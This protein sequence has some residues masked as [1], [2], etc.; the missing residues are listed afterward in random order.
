MTIDN[1]KDDR[2]AVRLTTRLH[3]PAGVQ[4]T[5]YRIVAERGNGQ[6]ALVQLCCTEAETAERLRDLVRHRRRT[7]RRHNELAEINDVPR[8]VWYVSQIWDGNA[9]VGQWRDLA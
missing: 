9:F 3:L 7:G 2:P 1:S 6:R 5:R 4:F 8:D